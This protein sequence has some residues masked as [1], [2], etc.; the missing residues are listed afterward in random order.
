LADVSQ[1]KRPDLIG[2][3]LVMVALAYGGVT[4][5]KG[6]PTS[7]NVGTAAAQ[8][9]GEAASSSTTTMAPTTTTPATTTTTMPVETVPVPTTAEP[10]TLPPPIIPP[11][12]APPQPAPGFGELTVTWVLNAAAAEGIDI[13]CDAPMP[14]APPDG[15]DTVA[16]NYLVEV[17]AGSENPVAATLSNGRRF[18]S[19]DVFGREL[20]TC[21]WDYTVNLSSTGPY[22]AHLYGGS[23]PSARGS[24]LAT[25]R[26][27]AESTTFPDLSHLRVCGTSPTCDVHNY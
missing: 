25:A 10:T 11:D 18:V 12:L 7:H 27:E 2:V 19:T 3:G 1:V 24:A 23:P 13:S 20:L 21:R 22:T 5:Y 4:I 6:K 16:A 8:A 26:V 9:D 14:G 17:T 15:D